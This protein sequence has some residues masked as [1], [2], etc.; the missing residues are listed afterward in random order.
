MSKIVVRLAAAATL[1]FAGTGIAARSQ[2][3]TLT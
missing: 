2:D 1:A 3:A